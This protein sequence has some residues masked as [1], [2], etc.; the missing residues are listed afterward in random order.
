MKWKMK[1]PSVVLTQP[2]P[3]L[4]A[5]VIDLCYYQLVHRGTPHHPLEF[6]LS[7]NLH[8]WPRLGPMYTWTQVHVLKYSTVLFTYDMVYSVCIKKHE[9]GVLFEHITNIF[10]IYRLFF[11]ISSQLRAIFHVVKRVTASNYVHGT[12]VFSWTN[13]T[14]EIV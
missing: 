12:F 1:H 13:N 4:N 10:T 3:Y 6:L 5:G 8:P 14:S 7:C 2:G 11:P 9:V